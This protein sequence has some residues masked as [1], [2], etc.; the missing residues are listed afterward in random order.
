MAGNDPKS[1][2]PPAARKA[3][4]R[5]L[6]EV[7]KPSRK[8][9]LN[10]VLRSLQ[11]LVNNELSTSPP[12]ESAKAKKPRKPAESVSN[13][14][15]H[16]AESPTSAQSAE[17]PTSPSRSATKPVPPEGL[18][19]EFE[20]EPSSRA[21]VQ[22]VT[23]TLPPENEL[24]PI[25]AV[26]DVPAVDSLPAEPLPDTP[27]L[28][29]ESPDITE[30]PSGAPDTSPSMDL[31]P[32]EPLT[33]PPEAPLQ[34]EAAD[35]DDLGE[36][37]VLEDIID[38]H[39]EPAGGEMP[40]PREARRLAIQVAARLN[41]ELRKAGKPG[42]SSDVITRLVRLLGEALANAGANMDNNPPGKD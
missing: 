40:E 14:G 29:P 41:V 34:A 26:E 13:T 8:V 42:L 20:L 31:A 23:E 9:A 19:Q 25:E 2:P 35:L 1:P 7:H 6:A 27:S 18:Q 33:E 15:R 16:P 21:P 37:P 5:D 3:K 39:D 12:A 36:I 17:P 38:L 28:E 32:L 24:A 10:E 30:S 4:P 22:D 11:D